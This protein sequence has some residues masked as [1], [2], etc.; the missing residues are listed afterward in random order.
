MEGKD[1][2]AGKKIEPAM[3]VAKL[4]TC[5]QCVLP[6][7]EEG[8]TEPLERYKTGIPYYKDPINNEN[9]QL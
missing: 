9:V 4:D 8:G 3:F 2:S 1:S 7:T 6:R 5:R